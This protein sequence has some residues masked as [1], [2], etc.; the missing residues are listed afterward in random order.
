MSSNVQK[1]LVFIVIVVEHSGPF[2][3][4]PLGCSLLFGM[5]TLNQ[6]Q[7][8]PSY[9]SHEVGKQCVSGTDSL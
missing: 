2:V 5:T 3:K 8:P 6:L 7:L 9:Y 4:Q 1:I